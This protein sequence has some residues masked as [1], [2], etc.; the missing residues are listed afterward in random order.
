[1]RLRYITG[2]AFTLFGALVLASCV[3]EAAI[4]LMR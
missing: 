2:G 3:E 1:M 4:I